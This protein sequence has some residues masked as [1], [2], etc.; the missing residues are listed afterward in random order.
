MLRAIRGQSARSYEAAGEWS[1]FGHG[2]AAVWVAVARRLNGLYPGWRTTTRVSV[3]P[4]E[5]I[6]TSQ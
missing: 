2:T 4:D 3:S 6:L 5:T 1:A